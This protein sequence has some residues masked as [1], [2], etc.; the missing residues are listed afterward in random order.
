MMVL[1]CYPWFRESKGLTAYLQAVQG[2][3]LFFPSAVCITDL[4]PGD[5]K[6][7]QW[8]ERH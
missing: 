6:R 7:F 1:W 8:T 5:K 2:S 4:D 3:A